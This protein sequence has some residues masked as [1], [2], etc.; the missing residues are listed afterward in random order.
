M[1]HN[2]PTNRLQRSLKKDNVKG[3]VDSDDNVTVNHRTVADGTSYWDVNVM[4]R[5]RKNDIK[6]GPNEE[7]KTEEELNNAI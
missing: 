1:T 6:V 7:F 2:S 3:Y 5:V 4:M